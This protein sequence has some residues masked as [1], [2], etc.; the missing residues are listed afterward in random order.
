MGWRRVDINNVNMPYY[1]ILTKRFAEWKP[2]DIA[3]I[4]DEAAKIPLEN[5]EI[6]L[7]VPGIVESKTIIADKPRRGRP[8]KK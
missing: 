2:G 5:G 4:D 8:K 1:K 6:V 3:A 7:Y